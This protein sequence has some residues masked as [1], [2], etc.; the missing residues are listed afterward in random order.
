MGEVVWDRG[1]PALQVTGPGMVP[2][3]DVLQAWLLGLR[4]DLRIALLLLLPLAVLGGIRALD[5][6]N[7]TTARRGWL[8][9]LAVA[10][11][12]TLLLHA[13]DL[14]Q[15]AYEEPHERKDE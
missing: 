15:Y 10:I 11:G 9:Y 14:G 8:V 3:A 6:A 5:P 1:I 7:S 12:A 2:A 13:V 4:F